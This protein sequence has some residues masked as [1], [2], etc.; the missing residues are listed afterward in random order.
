MLLPL[1]V[2]ILCLCKL[3]W[4]WWCRD[5]CLSY[6]VLATRSIQ[7]SLYDV[8]ATK[9]MTWDFVGTTVCVTALINIYS[10]KLS[11]KHIIFCH[12]LLWGY[13]VRFTDNHKEK[14]RLKGKVQ[15][16]PK[17]RFVQTNINIIFLPQNLWIVN[18][19]WFQI[20]VS[21]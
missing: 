13:N 12:I 16:N 5:Q 9:L 19:E 17:T 21:S 2:D 1:I 7:T 4:K 18:W 20:N 14:I 10:E 3:K 8:M 11:G 6:I 15:I